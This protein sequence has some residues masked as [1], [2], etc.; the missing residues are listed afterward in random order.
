[1]LQREMTTVYLA[2]MNR[3]LHLSLFCCAMVLFTCQEKDVNPEVITLS[4]GDITL[5]VEPALGARVSSL[6]FAGREILQTRR[7]SLGLQWGSTVWTSP[8]SD[9]NWPPITTFDSELFAVSQLREGVILLESQRDPDT[10][11]RMRKRISLGN[12]N[13][14]GLTYWVTNEGSSSVK[15]ALWE[16]TRIP[17]GGYLTFRSDSI[18]YSLDSTLVD[19]RTSTQYIYLDDRHSKPQKLFA[20]LREVPVSY[21]HDGLVL[22]KY[23][24]VKQLYRTAPGQAPLEIYIDP[25]TGFAEFE[26]QGDY[27]LIQPGES[28][29][30]RVRWEVGE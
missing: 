26:L 27:Q 19:T 1:M 10:F 28:A 9:W 17:Y 22:H 3:I 24:N 4:R 18:R 12:N 30:L 8:Q 5:S 2:P 11:L 25:V 7:D 23:T 14:V 6:T 29:N 21:H 15:V 13:D 20:D 16:N